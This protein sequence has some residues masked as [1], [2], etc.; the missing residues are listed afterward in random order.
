M[1]F[2]KLM[3]PRPRLGRVDDQ[4]GI[5]DT[6][7]SL[8]DRDNQGSSGQLQALWM[9]SRSVA[10]ITSRNHH[11]PAFFQIADVDIV[12]RDDHNSTEVGPAGSWL[13]R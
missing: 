13:A 12:I 3:T 8:S 7:P 2:G 11:P 5:E 9:M 1:G 10:R 4:A 6:H